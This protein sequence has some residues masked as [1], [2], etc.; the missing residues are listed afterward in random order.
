MPL[1]LIVHLFATENGLG[2]LRAFEAL[3]L[4]ILKDHGGELLDAFEPSGSISR[5]DDLPD[6]VHILRFPSQD[7]FA[8]YRADP[9]HHELADKRADA[10]SKTTIIA[11]GALVSYG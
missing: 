2:A 1:T 7:A 4:P 11:S 8:A 10:I 9:R 6:E 5:S 3:V